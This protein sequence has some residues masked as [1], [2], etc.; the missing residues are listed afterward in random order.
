MPFLIHRGRR[1]QSGRGLGSIF[2]SVFKMLIPAAKAAIKSPIARNILKAAKSAGKDAALSLASDAVAGRNM[3]ESLDR[4]LQDARETIGMSLKPT[5]PV[6]TRQRASKK[7]QR[8][9]SSLSY[10]AK[11]GKR[12]RDIFD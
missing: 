4:N 6:A 5:K 2:K 11:R 3:G 7:K 8:N 9:K 1:V 10:P 12:Q